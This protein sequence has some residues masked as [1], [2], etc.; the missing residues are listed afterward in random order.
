MSPNVPESTL[1]DIVTDVLETLYSYAQVKDR[2][3][4]LTVNVL[5]TDGQI[6]VSAT[7]SLQIQRNMIL[8]LCTENSAQ[9]ELIRVM[10]VNNTTGVITVARGVRNTTAQAWNAASTLVHVE[11]EYPISS[12]VREINHEIIGIVPD[13]WCVKNFATTVSAGWQIGYNMPQ[14]CQGIVK[15][16]YYPSGTQNFWEPVRRYRYDFTTQ[17]VTI[18]TLMQPGRPMNIV[19]R[20][21][22]TGMFYDTD[23]VN[24]T[25]LPSTCDELLTLGSAYRLISKRTSGRLVDTR[26][27]T[28]LTGQYR[29][30]SF[31][32]D[33][34]KSL[35][36]IYQA[37]LQ[38]ERERQRL[39]Y[40]IP[41]NY[42]F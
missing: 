36:A 33:A 6:T 8:Q 20:G 10:A 34:V 38:Q 27:E 3:V 1:V 2:I 40:P 35:Y 5:S 4:L 31:V 25:G 39:R 32:Q 11:P 22:P 17:I 7:D 12:I 16:E 26:A 9:S 18:L 29:Q 28:P 24:G 21:E 41:M 13:I 30:P 23:T 19:Y 42:T 37:R 14:D 15:I